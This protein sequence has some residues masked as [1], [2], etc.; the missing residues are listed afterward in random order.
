MG[1]I[2]QIILKLNMSVSIWRIWFSSSSPE[3]LLNILGCGKSLTQQRNRF[4]TSGESTTK[5]RVESQISQGCLSVKIRREVST[6]APSVVTMTTGAPSEGF[7]FRRFIPVTC[8]LLFFIFHTWSSE[9]LATPPPPKL[10]HFLH[11]LTGFSVHLASADIADIFPRCSKD[12]QM[13]LN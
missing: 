11:Y 8:K 2:C 12:I 13:L 5:N 3:L 10:A 9:K 6:L 7:D 1:N 4:S